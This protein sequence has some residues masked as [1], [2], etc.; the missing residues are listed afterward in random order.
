MDEPF[1]FTDIACS[2]WAN[3]CWI[4]ELF[5]T[6]MGARFEVMGLV[7]RCGVELADDV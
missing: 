7:P 3:C 2:F 4:W 1:E 6:T 5:I